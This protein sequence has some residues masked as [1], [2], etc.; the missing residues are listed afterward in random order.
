MI[1]CFSRLFVNK[2]I[3]LYSVIPKLYK[4]NAMTIFSRRYNRITFDSPRDSNNNISK[5]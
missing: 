3:K 1:C 2:Q 4:I 5:Y